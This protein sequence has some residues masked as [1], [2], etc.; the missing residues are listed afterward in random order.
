[1]RALGEE[2]RSLRRRVVIG[3]YFRT[4]SLAEVDD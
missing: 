4:P 3:K 1:M 2:R